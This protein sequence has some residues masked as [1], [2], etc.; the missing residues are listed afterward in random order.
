MRKLVSLAAAIALL[1][2]TATAQTLIYFDFDDQTD[3]TL[4]PGVNVDPVPANFVPGDTYVPTGDEVINGTLAADLGLGV[5]TAYATKVRTST[6][7]GPAIG[8][9]PSVGGS[10]TAGAKSL[11]TEGQEGLAVEAENGAGLQD[12]T[13]EVVWY[14]TDVAGTGNTAGIQVPYGNDPIGAQE[15]P[16]IWIRYVNV[17]PAMQYWTNRGDSNDEGIRVDGAIAANTLYHDVMILDYND[18]DPTASTVYAYRDGTLLGSD[19]FDATAGDGN[20]LFC[21]RAFGRRLFG[22]GIQNGGIGDP[23]P[24]GVIGGIDSFALSVGVLDPADFVLPSGNV[25]LSGSTS[26]V[27]NWS[28]YQ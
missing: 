10:V 26:D 6:A 12:Y 11:L 1:A 27:T 5:V 28:L 18:A 14:T 22:I 16:G 21:A 8:A 23:D 9:T 17:F 15:L 19:A 3:G 20:T 24:R 25:D 13:V 4:D 2:G 7:D